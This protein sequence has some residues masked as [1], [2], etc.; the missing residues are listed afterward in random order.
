MISHVEQLKCLSK[1]WGQLASLKSIATDISELEAAFY[2]QVRSVNKQISSLPVCKISNRFRDRNF[3][4][5][6]RGHWVAVKG[7][8]TPYGSLVWTRGLDEMGET[9]AF[10][11]AYRDESGRPFFDFLKYHSLVES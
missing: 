9:K 4:I 10:H 3:F 5:I 6:E 7:H 11:W 8:V 1:I 2:K